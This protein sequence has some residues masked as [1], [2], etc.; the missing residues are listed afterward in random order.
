MCLATNSNK[1]FFQDQ[2]ADRQI[3][4][5]NSRKFVQFVAKIIHKKSLPFREGFLYITLRIN[6]SSVE[7]SGL[8]NLAY[9]VLNLSIRPAVSISL[10]LP[11]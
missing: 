9:L 4:L 7:V 6:Y 3:T 8:L 11:V 5:I 10:D 1:I 2:S